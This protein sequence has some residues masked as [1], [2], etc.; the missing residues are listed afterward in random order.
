MQS[1]A[2]SVCMSEERVKEQK[3][4]WYLIE[5][6]FF[7]SSRRQ[8]VQCSLNPQRRN[9]Q[10]SGVLKAF[11][12]AHLWPY[13]LRTQFVEAKLLIKQTPKYLIYIF[14]HQLSP[15]Y[16]PAPGKH[17]NLQVNPS[18]FQ[19]AH[20]HLLKLHLFVLLDLFLIWESLQKLALLFYWESQWIK[21]NH[22]Y[23]LL[24]NT[25]LVCLWVW[26]IFWSRR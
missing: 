10:I 25:G 24:G 26:L 20:K 19:I 18:L 4:I 23:N 15:C 2:N 13:W 8:Q 7:L 14:A 11:F 1:E 22:T 6:I 12:E 17:I 21:T 9:S 5:F 3:V 16:T